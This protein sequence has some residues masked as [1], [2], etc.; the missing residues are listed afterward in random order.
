MNPVKLVRD[1]IP[2][3]MKSEGKNPIFY[4]A[5]EKEFCRLL[6][7]KLQEE[8]S[9]FLKDDSIEELCDILEVI[10]AICASKKMAMNDLEQ[11]R[12]KKINERGAFVNKFVLELT[13]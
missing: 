2:D 10:N 6:R 7:N 1:K 8:V 12:L 9:E 3:I 4:V 13:K 5:G 11:I